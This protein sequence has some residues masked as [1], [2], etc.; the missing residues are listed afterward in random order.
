MDTDTLLSLAEEL[1]TFPELSG[2]IQKGHL[3]LMRFTRGWKAIFRTPD[4][5]GD[6]S[7]VGLWPEFSTA[8]EAIRHLVLAVPTEQ[9]LEAAL[10]A[11]RF[12]KPKK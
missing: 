4:F 2:P 12:K 1:A 3:T 5:P 7:L 11:L 8:A 9:Q 6:R 10:E